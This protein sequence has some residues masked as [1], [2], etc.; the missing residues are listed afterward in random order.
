M[1]NGH[2]FPKEIILQAVYFKLRFRFSYSWRDVEELLLTR[3]VT[4]NGSEKLLPD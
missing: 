2:C 1:F 4:V 3:G